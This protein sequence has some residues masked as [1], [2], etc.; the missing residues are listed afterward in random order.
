MK[1]LCIVGYAD[2]KDLAPYDDPEAQI[3]GLNDLY[4]HIPRCNLW[5]QLHTPE[6]VDR[7]HKL[8][9][10][11]RDSWEQHK[12]VLREIGCPVYMREVDPDIPNSIKYPLEEICDHFGKCFQEPDHAKYFTNSVSY[13]L[14]LGIYKEYEKISVYGVDMAMSEEY[15]HQRPSCE[16]WLG[17]AAGRGI[18]IHIPNV[19][20]L[21]KT[22]YLYAYEE[23]KQR[24][25]EEKVHKTQ[26]DLKN[27]RE[28]I[29]SQRKQLR[30]QEL[31][32][33]GAEQVLKELM[34]NYE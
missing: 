33:A 7:T 9:P 24:A 34:I 21:L 5:L 23:E 10:E 11:T 28:A 13:M 26:N 4:K 25:F 29:V 1:H 14:A 15:G 12:Q 16:F 19:A 22:R 30:E 31:T 6:E 32:F 17:M 27:K 3:F 20:N 2:S 8:N 18:K